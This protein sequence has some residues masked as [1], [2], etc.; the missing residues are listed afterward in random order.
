MKKINIIY[1]IFTGLLLALMLMSGIQNLL[2]TEASVKL[3]S[4]QLKYPE[5]F[6]PFI[7]L[8][9]TLGA[10]A[11]LIPGY[12]R[13]KE[14]IYSGFTFDFTA[15]LYSTIATGESVMMWWPMLLFFVILAGSYIYY[16]KRLKASASPAVK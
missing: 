1:W 12:P 2:S 14:W 16:H 13:I 3:V 15:A 4:G 11:M 6:I 8:A 9:K 10:V 7:G 5:Y